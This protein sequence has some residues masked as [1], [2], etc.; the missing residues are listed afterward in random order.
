MRDAGGDGATKRLAKRKLDAVG[1][2]NAHSCYANSDA[3]LKRFRAAAQ[4]AASLAEISRTQQADSAA[5]KA[6][7][8]D[9]LKTV[10][11]AALKKLRSKQ[12]LFEKLTINEL[13][14]L[15]YEYYNQTIVVSVKV[16]VVEAVRKLYKDNPNR[17]ENVVIVDTP[18]LATSDE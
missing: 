17:L 14:S 10:A 8:S 12:M 7:E 18:P 4:L 9:K 5:K 1:Y 11:P 2:V 16:Q 13:R 6:G 15:A 3:R